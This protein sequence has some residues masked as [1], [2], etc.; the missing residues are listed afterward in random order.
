VESGLSPTFRFLE[1]ELEPE[2]QVPACPVPFHFQRDAYRPKP[3]RTPPCSTARLTPQPEEPI[4]PVVPPGLG[5][6]ASA[7]DTKSITSFGLIR[8]ALQLAAIVA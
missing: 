8:S 4:P 2:D 6:A 7:V 5:T 1:S 3:H